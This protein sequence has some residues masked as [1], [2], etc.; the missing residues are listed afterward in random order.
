MKKLSGVAM[1]ANRSSSRATKEALLFWLVI[2][3]SLSN[4]V[5]V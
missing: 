5:Y 2:L 1:A 4:S 3:P